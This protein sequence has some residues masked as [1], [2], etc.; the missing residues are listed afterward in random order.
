LYDIVAL[1]CFQLPSGTPSALTGSAKVKNEERN[2][3]GGK[4]H[5]G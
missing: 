1:Q 4:D 3:E 2:G 5:P